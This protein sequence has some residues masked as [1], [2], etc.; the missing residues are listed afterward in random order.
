MCIA[1]MQGLRVFGAAVRPWIHFFHSIFTAAVTLIIFRKQDNIIYL[2]YNDGETNQWLWV[3]LKYIKLHFM[4]K[5]QGEQNKL[6]NLLFCHNILLIL[7]MPESLLLQQTKHLL[8]FPDIWIGIG[9]FYNCLLAGLIPCSWSPL[10]AAAGDSAARTDHQ[11]QSR[12][13]TCI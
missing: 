9:C 6:S 1:C 10:N 4:K 5:K 13:I 11:G 2:A 8:H 3:S 12:N 7:E